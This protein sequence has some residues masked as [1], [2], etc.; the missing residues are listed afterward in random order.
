MISTV[1]REEAQK[2]KSQLCNITTHPL[3]RHEVMINNPKYVYTVDI[4]DKY[5]AYF[6]ITRGRE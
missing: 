4:L 2:L 5:R 6:G 3:M 1:W